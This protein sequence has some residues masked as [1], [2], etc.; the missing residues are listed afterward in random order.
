MSYNQIG[1]GQRE[2]QVKFS[3]SS[4][5]E[6]N[7]TGVNFSVQQ[8]DGS[9]ANF[10]YGI[11]N[12]NLIT[13]I[14]SFNFNFATNGNYAI[15]TTFN[16]IGGILDTATQALTTRVHN[17]VTYA[18]IPAGNYI[19][20]QDISTYLNDK[21][22]TELS[23]R[24]EG[25]IDDNT[26]IQQA[27]T[28]A[29]NRFNS[30]VACLNYQIPLIC[31]DGSIPAIA[32]EICLYIAVWNMY[33]GRRTDEVDFRYNEAIHM[34][35]GFKLGELCPVCANGQTPLRPAIAISAISTSS[36]GVY[37]SVGGLSSFSDGLC[38]TYKCGC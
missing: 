29:E 2:V 32:K 35:K 11:A 14:A 4:Q 1:Q 15:Q 27:I 6:A 3:L 17:T 25:E 26:K 28:I 31:A 36:S 13:K 7:L 18:V 24:D 37:A 12:I 38:N 19:N 16:F 23:D 33:E 9:I 21:R 10:N 22:L 34:L 5:D 30:Y 20:K 8:P